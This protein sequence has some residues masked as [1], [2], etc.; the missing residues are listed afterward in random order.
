MCFMES[1]L[2]WSVFSSFTSDSVGCRWAAACS[3]VTDL[4]APSMQQWHAPPPPGIPVY[5]HWPRPW[6]AGQRRTGGGPQILSVRQVIHELQ[7]NAG[8][9]IFSGVTVGMQFMYCCCRNALQ[10]L[11]HALTMH[12]QLQTAIALMP[13][14]EDIVKVVIGITL[15]SWYVSTFLCAFQ[16]WNNR[17]VHVAVGEYEQSGSSELWEIW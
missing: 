17:V 4:P 16:P 10:L 11:M 9:V 5:R 12:R 7:I 13:H 1:S 3:T 8:C 15:C 2:H 6:Q 14:W